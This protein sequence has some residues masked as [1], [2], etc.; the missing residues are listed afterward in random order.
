[1]SV[2][3]K[4][5]YHHFSRTAR[6][7]LIAETRPYREEELADTTRAAICPTRG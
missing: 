1:M 2:N 7:F 3:S 6:A 5:P 4:Y